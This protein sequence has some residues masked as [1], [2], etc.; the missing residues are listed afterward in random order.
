[1]SIEEL[2]KRA[3]VIIGMFPSPCAK[4]MIAQPSLYKLV[5]M[6]LSRTFYKEN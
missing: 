2:V 3:L 1:M 6:I 4:A 5:L